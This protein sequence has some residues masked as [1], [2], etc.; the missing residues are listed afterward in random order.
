[1]KK[2]LVLFGGKSYEYD[3]SCLSAKTILENIDRTIYDVAAVGIDKSNNWYIFNDDLDSIS[4]SPL[5]DEEKALALIEEKLQ[6]LF[7]AKQAEQAEILRSREIVKQQISQ[8]SLQQK[9]SERRKGKGK[10]PLQAKVRQEIAYQKAVTGQLASMMAEMKDTSSK[11][12]ADVTAQ[13]NESLHRSAEISA[14]IS[15]AL[16]DF[17]KT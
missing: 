15:R 9:L 6:S 14:Q 4:P 2:V 10:D 5:E 16:H 12:K 11:I 1:M 3:I 13:L 7:A 17:T 8:L